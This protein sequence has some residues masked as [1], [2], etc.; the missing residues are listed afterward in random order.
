MYLGQSEGSVWVGS[1]VVFLP[2]LVSLT[3]ADSYFVS[4]ILGVIQEGI[5]NSM[6][7]QCILCG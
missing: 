7:Q 3:A 1:E 6:A 2:Q 5:S 4:Q